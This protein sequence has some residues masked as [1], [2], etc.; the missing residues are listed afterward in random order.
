MSRL[1]DKEYWEGLYQSMAPGIQVPPK[2]SSLKLLMKK[3]MG[4]RLFEI[5][6]AYDDYLLWQVVFPRYF[7]ADCTQLSIVEIGS[8]P[9]DFLV[10][11]AK[12][13]GAQPY[14]VEYTS[15]GAEQN[16]QSFLANGISA[17][18]VIEADFFSDDFLEANR[19][20]F[21]IVISRGF[22]EHFVEVEAVV[23]RHTALL[24]KGGLLFILIPNLRGIYY[25]WTRNFNPEQLPLHNLDLMRLQKFR[26]AFSPSALEI[27]RCSYFGTFSFW[28]FTAPAVEHRTNKVI[29]FLHI[30][31]R[32]L[33]PLLRLVFGS[34]GCE[35]AT[36]S[37]N[38]IFIGKKGGR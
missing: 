20:R 5:L 29:R 13:F 21:D 2:E 12:T 27:L 28:M 37:P 32:G 9:G 11:F 19:E 35:S 23:A 22:I 38:L 4:R 24:K 18:N 31:Q 33:N 7:P 15:N 17:E 6:T 26:E 30:V 14:G 1:T 16:R 8:A 34:T 25:P 3:L 36:F 10:R